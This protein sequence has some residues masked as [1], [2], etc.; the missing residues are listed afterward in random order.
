M[1]LIGGAYGPMGYETMVMREV[2]VVGLRVNFHIADSY[3]P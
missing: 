1:R 3:M 2:V